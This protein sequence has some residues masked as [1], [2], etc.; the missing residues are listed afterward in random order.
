MPGAEEVLLAA[1]KPAQVDQ[2][3]GPL[4]RSEL[5]STLSQLK[6]WKVRMGESDWGEIADISVIGARQFK[7]G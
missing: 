4:R 7:Q 6:Q 1:A 5:L 3:G 2:T